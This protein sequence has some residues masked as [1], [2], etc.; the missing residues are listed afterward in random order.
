MIFLISVYHLAINGI[1][2]CTLNVIQHI[3]LEVKSNC[4]DFIIGFFDN[5]L[6]VNFN[7]EVVQS[8][9]GFYSVIGYYNSIAHILRSENRLLYVA[10]FFAVLITFLIVLRL[11]YKRI[12]RGKFNLEKIIQQRTDEILDQKAKLEFQA[13]QL[14]IT[15]RKLRQ[16]SI[17]ARK[18]DNPVIIVNTKG[19]IDWFNDCFFKYFAING[20]SY[21]YRNIGELFINSEIEKEL[22]N[23]ITTRKPIS[24]CEKFNSQIMG[25][26]WFQVTITPVLDKK[27]SVTNLIIICSDITNIVELNKV[28]DLITSIIT[29]DLKSPLLGFSLF[30]KT[31]AQNLD[32]YDKEQIKEGLYTMHN[33]ASSIYNLLE[34][35]TDWFK[36]QRGSVSF[37]PTYL[38][39]FV[40]TN[41][42]FSLFEHQ[43]IFKE[44]ILVN[45][46]SPGIMVYA[47][48]NMVR[49]ILRNLISNAIKFS[50]KGSI[51]VNSKN[52]GDEHEISVSDNG[53]MMDDNTKSKLFNSKNNE[54]FGLLICEEFVSKNGGKIWIDKSEKRTTIKFTLPNNYQKMIK[55]RVCITDDSEMFCYGVK[56]ILEIT[57][58]YEIFITSSSHELFKLLK[59]SEELPHLLLLDIKLK[60]SNS[61]NGIEIASE[62]KKNF[63][64]IKIIILTSYDDKEV[65][66]KSLE[67]GIDGFL[68][69]E[70]VA[71]ELIEAIET[72]LSNQN[73]LG[74]TI[75]FQSINHVFSKQSK[76]L[77]VLTKTENKVFLMICKGFLNQQISDSLNISVHTVE[78]HR[79][80]I[81]NKLSIKNDV[82][83]IK[84]AIDENLEEIMKYYNI[85]KY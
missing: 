17:V 23:C 1:K 32:L 47:D 74:K 71:D 79:S 43:A 3:C 69:K 14:D 33:N 10:G 63:P 75:P 12:S 54:G 68:P 15:N 28:R 45:N 82:D 30:S 66:T 72:V 58:K 38:N 2:L 62:V 35:L 84:I 9:V 41:E 78:S 39:L 36:S 85:Q 21:H 46:V 77:D 29:H 6:G 70:A 18:T 59:K 27:N 37:L 25:E 31:L 4:S 64:L 52:K 16:L 7:S 56:S 50:E 65:L 22:S 13:N 34:N 19:E 24:Y 44:I 53:P 11:Y 40:T 60:K 80:N 5:F 42:V 51:V 26:V 48:E 83:Y 81:K 49:T 57:N 67:A 55:K 73:Y 8:K 76:K 20:K 61:L